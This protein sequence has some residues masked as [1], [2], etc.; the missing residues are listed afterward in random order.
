ML[1]KRYSVLLLFF[2]VLSFISCER[3][4]GMPNIVWLIAE[5]LSPDLACYGHSLVQTPNIDSLAVAGMR[6]ENAYS[7]SPVCSPSR[8]GFI[9]GMV[10]EEWII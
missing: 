10:F 1:Y 9:T 6:F 8:S 3:D 7:T 2:L 4:S 5:D